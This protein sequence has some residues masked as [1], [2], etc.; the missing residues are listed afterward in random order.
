MKKLLRRISAVLMALPLAVSV[1]PPVSMAAERTVD[2]ILSDAFVLLFRLFMNGLMH[3]F[4]SES[5]P[6]FKDRPAMHFPL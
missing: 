3:S 4:L 2:D 1:L 6:F 5:V